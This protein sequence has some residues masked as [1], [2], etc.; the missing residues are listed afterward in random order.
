MIDTL[1]FSEMAELYLK[2]KP[3]YKANRVRVGKFAKANG[4]KKRSQMINGHVEYFYI[5]ED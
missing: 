3:I 4:Y 2:S 1:T 5:K